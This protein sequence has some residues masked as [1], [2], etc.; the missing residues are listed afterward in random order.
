MNNSNIHLCPICAEQNKI[1]EEF[2]KKC[3]W[4]LI[5]IP[6]NAFADENGNIYFSGFELRKL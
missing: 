2:C 4:E 1:D 6:K 3:A 5:D